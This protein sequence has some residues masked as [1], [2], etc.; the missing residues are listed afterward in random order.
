[1]DPLDCLLVADDLTGACD[2]AVQFAARGIATSV[3]VSGAP[4]DAR[5]LAISSESRDLPAGAIARAVESAIAVCPPAERV[6]K[7]I[8]S[9]LRGNPGAEIDAACAALGCDAAVI[10]PA[11]PALHRVVER[12]RLRVTHSPDFEAIDVAARIGCGCV[13]GDAGAV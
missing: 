4:D 1:M 9:T 8:D 11:F 10:C 2:A 6:F 5:V 13:H 7:K 3:L 12:G